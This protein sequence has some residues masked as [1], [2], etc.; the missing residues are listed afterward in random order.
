MDVKRYKPL[1]FGIWTL[2]CVA[3]VACTT[4][5]FESAYT[6][7]TDP[8]LQPGQPIPLPAGRPLLTVTGNIQTFNQDN[9]LLFD[10]A[11]LESIGQVEYTVPDPFK[12]QDVTYRGVLMR[13]LI[14]LWQV[15]ENAQILEI[16][17]LNDYKVDAPLATFVEF[18][19][20]LAFQADGVYMK[21]EDKGPGM[22]VF[23][24][25]A[26]QFERPLHDNYWVWQI[27]KITVK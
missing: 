24:Y 10:L 26:Y 25:H 14:A 12:G 9:S 3:L 18:P 1:F 16:E 17:G 15:G 13:D 8:Q 23:P 20:I 5:S 7:V 11:T 27:E 4:S 22:I 19:V 6:V 2:F 21:V